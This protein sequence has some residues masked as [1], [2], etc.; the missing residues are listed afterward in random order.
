MYELFSHILEVSII[1]L[2]LYILYL[3]IIQNFVIITLIELCVVFSRLR[4]NVPTDSI[5]KYYST[6][7]Y[8][9]IKGI[10]PIG[11]YYFFLCRIP[12]NKLYIRLGTQSSQQ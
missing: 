2:T 4:L 5:V 7:D 1:L 11:Y 6:T 8:K 3:H 9:S 12:K 10:V